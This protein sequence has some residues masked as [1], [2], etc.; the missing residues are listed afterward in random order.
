E[1][2]EFFERFVSELPR[3]RIHQGLCVG[4]SKLLESLMNCGREEL[5]TLIEAPISRGEALPHADIVVPK[6]KIARLRKARVSPELEEWFIQLLY[7]QIHLL[8]ES[9]GQTVPMRVSEIRERC[10]ILDKYVPWWNESINVLC[11][12]QYLELRDGGIS[13]THAEDASV[14]G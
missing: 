2:F 13:E 6:E 7:H 11:Q 3:R 9:T 5:I 4:E 10:W 8:I 1:G 14:I 12:N